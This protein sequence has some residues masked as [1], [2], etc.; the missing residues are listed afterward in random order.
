MKEYNSQWPPQQDMVDR[1]SHSKLNRKIE[2]WTTGTGAQ[3]SILWGVVWALS[4]ILSLAQ[5]HGGQ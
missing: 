4:V 5:S 2:A 1:G 3:W